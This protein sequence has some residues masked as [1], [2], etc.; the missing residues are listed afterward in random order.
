[1]PIL[2]FCGDSHLLPVKYGFK[3]GL[4]A[5]FDCRFEAVGGATAVGLRHPT[6]KK[7]ALVRYR[8]CLLPFDPEVIPIFQLGEV[9]CGFVAWVRSQRYGE[10][11]PDQITQA[12]DAYRG[13]LC[14]IK[15]A[16]YDNLIVTSATPPTLRDGELDGD[17]AHLRREVQATYRERSDLTHDYNRR[18]AA[19]CQSEGFTFVNLTPDFTDPQTGLLNETFRNTDPLD[20]H[21]QNDVAS[22][23]WA[24]R[25][26]KVVRHAEPDAVEA[27]APDLPSVIEQ[28]GGSGS[29]STPCRIEKLGV[30]GFSYANAEKSAHKLAEEHFYTINLGDSAQTIAMRQLLDGLGVDAAQVETIDRDTLPTYSGAP[31]ALLMNGVFFDRNFPVSDKITPIFVG[32][33]T[34]SADAVRRNRDWFKQFEP[35]GCRDIH[36]TTLLKAE[37][38]V[39]YVTGCVTATFPRRTKLPRRGRV[40]VVHGLQAGQLPSAV[41][42]HV[43]GDLLDKAEFIFHRLPVNEL[44]LSSESR[45]WIEHYEQHLLDRYRNEASFVITPLLHVASPCLA[46]GV[47]VVVVRKNLDTRFGFL[48]TLIRVH[49][50]EDLDQIDWHPNA[51]DIRET[52]RA[53]NEDVERRIAAFRV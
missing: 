43:P 38:I 23:V 39:A 29:P 47:P 10:S 36:T 53:F 34:K 3:R 6:S 2:H 21:L 19:I 46:M 17:V 31:V 42:K 14:E 35:I 9:D 32:F 41:L 12:L 8:S 27:P 1:M 45:S 50:P 26:L 18:L 51:I 7:Q 5:P 48:Q 44:P 4:F 40:F 49:T 24:R 15:A 20:H 52:A 22:K 16:G 37:G 13:F 11:V 30:L 28:S 33:C 25:I